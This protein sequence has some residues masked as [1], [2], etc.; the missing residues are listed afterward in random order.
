MPKWIDLNDASGARLKIAE[1]DV[2]GERHLH[3]FITGLSY[4]NP[5]W[6]KSIAQLGFSAGGARKYLV[7][8]VRPGERP[9]AS[10][11]RPIFPQVAVRE[12]APESYMLNLQQARRSD[13]RPVT[14]EERD[15]AI[16]INNAVLLGRNSDGDRVFEA[17]GSRYLI[18][19]NA[20]AAEVRVVES[21]ASQP[22]VFLRMPADASGDARTK[23]LLQ[24]ADGFVR[25]MVLG[26]VQHTEDTERFLRAI[27]GVKEDGEGRPAAWSSE[28]H[29]EVHAAIETALLRYLR[30]SFEVAQDAYG[31]SARLTDMLPP[32]RGR[33]RGLGTMPTPLSVASQRLLGDTAGLTVVV[34][35]AFDGASFAFLAEGTTVRAY[36]GTKDMEAL[37]SAVNVRVNTEWQ[38]GDFAA[39]REVGADALFINADPVLSADGRRTD[40]MLAINALRSLKDGGRA[41]IVVAADAVPGE[42][43]PS[44]RSFLQM[45]N[46]R[47]QIQAAFET[48][49]ILSR[50]AGVPEGSPG[51]RVLSV[52]N[53][54]VDLP[55]PIANLPVISSWDELKQRVD[56]AMAQAKVMDAQAQGVDV[57][58][59]ALEGRVQRPYIAFSRVGEARTMVPSNMQAPLQATLTRIEK[60]F[61]QVDGLVTRELGWSESVLPQRFSPEQVDGVS[62]MIVR[63]LEGYASILADETGV[64]KGRQLAA[65]M[66]WALRR[67]HPVFFVT[68]RANLFSDMAND[69][70]AIGEWD[71]VRPMIMNTDGEITWEP[72]PGAAPVVLAQGFSAARTRAMVDNGIKLEDE[73]L[74]TCF[75]T[76]SQIAGADSE[77]A[78]WV[79]NQLGNALIIFD[80]SHVAA[81][82]DSQIASHVAE[83][84]RL[85]NG[86]QFASATWSKSEDNLHIYSRALPDSVNVASLAAAI[87]KGG[88]SFSEV[89]SSMLASEGALIRREHDLSKLEVSVHTVKERLAYN[90]SVS[91]AVAEALGA[92]TYLAGDMSAIF[93]RG[94]REAVSVL[95]KAKEAR[96]AI[97]SSTNAAAETPVSRANLMS[98]SFGTGSV[99]YQVM[100]A[101]QG[102]LNAEQV[103]D[104]AIEHIRA[105]RKPV[106]VSEATNEA[107]TRML[108]QA[109]SEA[110]N[111]SDRVAGGMPSLIRM[112]TI[113]DAVRAVLMPRLTTV[114]QREI[115]E[116]D[117]EDEAEVDPNAEGEG[118]AL[119]ASDDPEATVA[120][121]ELVAAR[122]DQALLRRLG[123]GTADEPQEDPDAVNLD[124]ALAAAPDAAEVATS[125]RV[126]VVSKRKTVSIM[127]LP[128][129]SDADRKLFADGVKAL[130][131]LIA[132][133]PEIPVSAFDVIEQRLRDAGI[134]VGEITGRSFSLERAPAP[135]PLVQVPAVTV[136]PGATVATYE[137]SSRDASASQ[138]SNWDP[139]GSW[140]VVPRLRSKRAVNA[141][142]RAFNNGEIQALL[143]NRSAATGASMHASPRF[144]DQSR[145]V[146]LE[147]QIPEN[148]TD[149]IQLIGRVNRYDQVS[150]PLVETC[151]T[152][153][154]GE[155]RYVM[156]QNRKLE[157]MSANVRASPENAMLVKNVRDLF[158]SIGLESVRGYV[159]DEPLVAK[160]LAL[161]E[162][163]LEQSGVPAVN[164]F[165]MRV[166]LL[167]SVEQHHVYDQLFTRFDESFDRHELMGTNPLKTREYDWRAKEEFSSVFFGD[168][169]GE[170]G[171]AVEAL[172]REVR[173]DGGAAAEGATA[174]PAQ[175]TLPAMD[176]SEMV[177]AGD[178]AG[179]GEQDDLLSAFD[180]PVFVKKI[181]FHEELK[182]MSWGACVGAAEAAG[183]MLAREGGHLMR[184]AQG[185]VCWK[186]EILARLNA[187]MKA[188]VTMAAVSAGITE[189]DE[190]VLTNN[191]AQRAHLRAD[192]LRKHVEG[193][194][195]GGVFVEDAKVDGV[196][197]VIERAR[198]GVIV[199]MKLPTEARELIHPHKWR[200]M[201][202]FP[203]EE[204]PLEYSLRALLSEVKGG[205]KVGD[206]TG[207]LLTTS[208]GRLR[209]AQTAFGTNE[210]AQQAQPPSAEKF[211]NVNSRVARLNWLK[212]SFDL[213][214]TGRQRRVCYVLGG[215]MYMAYDWSVKSRVGRSIIYTDDKGMRQ[216]G[217][218]LPATM[219]HVGAHFMPMR[220]WGGQIKP[221]VKRLLEARGGTTLTLETEF[222]E[223]NKP[224]G[225]QI[226][227]K[228]ILV[229]MRGT[230][231][232]RSLRLMRGEQAKMRKEALGDRATAGSDPMNVTLSTLSRKGRGAAAAEQQA[233]AAGD[234][235]AAA[236]PRTA[237]P[238]G[239]V[240]LRMGLDTTVPEHLDRA[241][242][243]LMRGTGLEIY[244]KGREQ[245]A[246]ARD[247]GR[248][249]FERVR[250]ETAQRRDQVRQEISAA[251]TRD[252]APVEQDGPAA[253]E[254]LQD[255]RQVA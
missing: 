150:F 253:N 25:S 157:K 125:G 176:V 90:E 29:D 156:M 230:D 249:H 136:A 95:R 87:K 166:P 122:R 204:K 3:L 206:V 244:A 190:A 89:L 46:E 255:E 56:E 12:M 59:A 169:S 191:G 114:V 205:V 229:L 245:R 196:G 43:A 173:E 233:E 16:D 44:S 194:V 69:L 207:S 118:L 232:R 129:M 158:N 8:R 246:L 178:G 162:A 121:A 19:L 210:E 238:Q 128:G 115:T 21:D 154:Y 133:I 66:A 34:P 20:Q 140:K 26:E 126:R 137:P 189:H 92:A 203:G 28:L 61:G 143:I 108:A 80:E 79:K 241:L 131:R 101:V 134:T 2:G 236:A 111:P 116:E 98:S 67:N 107:L 113:R 135:T 14:R 13:E 93:M 17:A 247:V 47:Y 138:D 192:W 48:A 199:N 88:E 24:C 195:P 10:S 119:E 148:V 214:P 85:A 146:L 117:I 124:D 252:D 185:E 234:D 94:N 212:D 4:L 120:N 31:E 239:Y 42:L 139:A 60:L 216:R 227:D 51:L 243:L 32:F 84:S 40:Y 174:D 183:E 197:N 50:K 38:E 211:L 23:A 182:P 149:R 71:R 78:Q 208:W 74:N 161:P 248:E 104:R 54:R 130:E 202:V 242:D 77:K 198:E 180:R 58:R 220:V 30:D 123:T 53:R 218:L 165:L 7:R 147:H 9:L 103:A 86:V 100:K 222:M 5:A 37:S 167:K 11:F 15:A 39:A 6:A 172:V 45:I 200:I 27:H 237:I 91:D 225:L 110:T 18:K 57:E 97:V 1:I 209:P 62:M 81:G 112:P 155:L 96:A 184:N 160:K 171:N 35:N 163:F 193:L 201:V 215:N 76:Y 223:T 49:P 41:V 251:A 75:L 177:A 145:R 221:F 132:A 187:G 228:S 70:K 36:R 127:D 217:V 63:Q 151:T 142:K 83:M 181:A 159:Q 175:A 152:G 65:L 153:I 186:P 144:L 164:T 106:I 52:V 250:A 22:H 109:D 33:L 55:T 213:S 72:A 99:L 254:P 231:A 235:T 102:A 64:G 82:S 179:G 219:S 73:G 188:I 141:V 226:S 105:G 68:D 224:Y 168:P 240:A 170:R